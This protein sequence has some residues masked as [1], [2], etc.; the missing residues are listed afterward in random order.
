M[1]S[2]SGVGGINANMSPDAFHRYATHY[3][4]CRR[5]FQCPDKFSPVPY[6]LLC[7]AIELEIKAR[8]LKHKTQK[9]VKDDF[10]HDLEKAYNAL[11][12]ND[13]TLNKEEEGTLRLA[14]DIYSKKDFEYFS[15]KDALTGYKRFR[16][17]ELKLDSIA[18]K[19]I[20]TFQP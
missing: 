7:R 6:F 2:I 11:E 20:E 15:P 12:P 16:G 17:L 18:S 4:K 13:K 1:Q 3:L 14:S 19:L 10:S 5:D 9:Q 8:H